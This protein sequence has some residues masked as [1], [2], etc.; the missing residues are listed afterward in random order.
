MLMAATIIIAAIARVAIA[1]A[2]VKPDIPKQYFFLQ[3]RFI[4]F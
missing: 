3:F 4:C 2:S 1:S